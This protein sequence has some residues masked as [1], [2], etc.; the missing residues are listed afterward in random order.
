MSVYNKAGNL[1]EVRAIGAAID[2]RCIIEKLY[3]KLFAE[4]MTALE[5]R[6]LVNYMTSAIE[7]AAVV[8]LS[9]HQLNQ[10]L[11]EGQID[12]PGDDD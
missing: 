12:P 9:K 2:V 1:T 6:A 5:G 10:V 8:A 3:A 11:G 4:G 7:F